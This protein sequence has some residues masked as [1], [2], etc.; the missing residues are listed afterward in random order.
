[1]K[2]IKKILFGILIFSLIGLIVLCYLLLSYNNEKDII[3]Y[4]NNSSLFDNYLEYQIL[5]YNK[6]FDFEKFRKWVSKR[7]EKLSE[8]MKMDKFHYILSNNSCEFYWTNST[9][10]KVQ[11]SGTQTF[12]DYLTK[13]ETLELYPYTK[14]PKFYKEGFYYEVLNDSLIEGKK[15]NIKPLIDEYKSVLNCDNV[16]PKTGEKRKISLF[17]NSETSNLGIIFSDFSTQSEDMIKDKILEL[18]NNSK[19]SFFLI[20]DFYDIKDSTCD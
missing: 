17:F 11:I 4:V 20:F 8:I 1:M 7:D 14:L 13:N 9:K 10:D 19:K 15:M 12:F 3:K 18:T 16:F 2:K 6:E 5:H